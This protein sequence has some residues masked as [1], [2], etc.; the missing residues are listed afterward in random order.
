MVRIAL[1]VMLMVGVG[2]VTDNA[3]AKNCKDAANKNAVN[4][5]APE[6]VKYKE[7]VDAQGW[8]VAPADLNAPALTAEDLKAVGMDLNLPSKQYLDEKKYNLN[9]E[10]ADVGVGHVHAGMDGSV[11]LGGKSLTPPTEDTDCQ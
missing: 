1:Y 4:Y 2:V 6:D 3:E 9:L 11:T 7:G 5:V 10:R 8:A